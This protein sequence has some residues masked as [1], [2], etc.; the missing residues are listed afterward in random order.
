[1]PTKLALTPGG[2]LGKPRRQF[3]PPANGMGSRGALAVNALPPAAYEAM[4]DARVR[5]LSS[6]FID[7]YGFF[8][9]AAGGAL[10]EEE[11]GSGWHGRCRKR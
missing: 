8:G 4:D 1:V 9:G 6:I 2:E 5:V 7:I 11:R 3:L 10:E